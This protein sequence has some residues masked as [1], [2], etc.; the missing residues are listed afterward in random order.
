MSLVLPITCGWHRDNDVQDCQFYV[1]LSKIHILTVKPFLYMCIVQV[2][3]QRQPSLNEMGVTEIDLQHTEE[4][5][6][7]VRTMAL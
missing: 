3:Q 7:I 2:S 1:F 4:E 6:E 5:R